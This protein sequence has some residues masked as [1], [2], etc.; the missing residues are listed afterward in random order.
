MT[1]RTASRVLSPCGVLRKINDLCQLNAPKDNAIRRLCADGE[2]KTKMF[3]RELNKHDKNV[4]KEWWEENVDF[5]KDIGLRLKEGYLQGG[6]KGDIC[7]I[8]YEIDKL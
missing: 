6:S 7:K 2:K 5:D 3:A 1:I 8:K 4:W